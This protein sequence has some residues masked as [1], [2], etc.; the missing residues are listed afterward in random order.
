MTHLHKKRLQAATGWVK[1][2]PTRF[3]RGY[4]MSCVVAL[5]RSIICNTPESKT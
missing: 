2:E 1:I 5:I 4:L 3:S